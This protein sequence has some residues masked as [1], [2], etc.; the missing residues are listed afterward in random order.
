MPIN[1]PLFTREGPKFYA[2]A[3]AHNK[4]FGTGAPYWTTLD[5]ADESAFRLWVAVSDVPFDPNAEIVDYDMRGYWLD[6]IKPGGEWKKGDH[7]PDTYK[8]PYDTSFSGESRYAVPGTPFVWVGDQLKDT[9]DEQIIFWADYVPPPP[10]RNGNGGQ[11]ASHGAKSQEEGT[12]KSTPPY[13]RSELEVSG[14]DVDLKALNLALRGFASEELIENVVSAEIER[15][16]EGASTFTIEVVDYDRILQ[17]SPF[18]GKDVFTE[19]DGLWFALAA[20]AKNGNNFKLTM[21]DREVYFLRKYNSP[22]TAAWGTTTR[23]KF[24]RDM[25]REVKEVGIIF[26]C[27][28]IDSIIPEGGDKEQNSEDNREGG[29]SFSS[30]VKVKGQPADPEQLEMINRILRVG[31]KMKVSQRLAIAAIDTATV[32]S[33]LHNLKGGDRDSAGLFQ[34]RPSQ[35][36]GSYSEVTN[37]EHASQEFFQHAIFVEIHDPRIS[38]PDLCQRVQNSGFPERYRDWVEE[39]THTVELWGYKPDPGQSSSGNTQNPPPISDDIFA[40]S[41]A[42]AGTDAFQFTRGQFTNDETGQQ[43]VERENSWDCSGRLADEV[44]WRRFM[45]SGKF[46]YA[47]ETYLFK[48]KP[49]IILTG[50]FQDAVISVDYDYDSRKRQAIVTITALADR[51]SAP[52]GSVIQITNMGVING[53]YLVSNIRRPLFDPVATINCVKPRPA[54]PEPAQ[55]QNAAPSNI[56]IDPGKGTGSSSGYIYPLDTP[57]HL[58]KSEFATI[59]AEGAPDKYGNRHHAAKD[60]FAPGGA[61]VRAP[62]AGVVVEVKQSSGNSGQIFGGVVKLQMPGGQVWVF[63]HVNPVVILEVGARVGQGGILASVTRWA[64]NPSSSHCHIEFWK[65]LSGG[66]VYEN[67]CDPCRIFK[68]ESC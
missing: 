3:Y 47:S 7:F 42:G 37:P 36:W 33:S 2:A 19:I 48:S 64:D 60:W 11:P 31:A 21:E 63:R 26:V 8:T 46:W 57:G 5:D 1:V 53:K 17:S 58:E 45:V 62:A 41:G 24:I 66:Y 49:R 6:I 61:P 4:N 16:I 12:P 32:E 9:R 65:T 39:A 52:P 44:Q 54:L 20:V 28:E 10:S 38:I 15:T 55:T 14:S 25:V 34:Q 68:G 23:P 27:P 18:V 50:E 30:G 43:K 59:D 35:G 29:I 67:M 22:K 40:G 13:Q 56:G 51:W